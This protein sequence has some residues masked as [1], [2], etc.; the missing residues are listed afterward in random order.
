[1]KLRL[2]N[3][4]NNWVTINDKVKFLIDYPTRE[5]E[6]KLQRMLFSDIRN[7]ANQ[8]D[9]SQHLLK[10]TIKNWEGVTDDNDNEVK[11]EIVNNE[12]E[13]TLWWA[14][15]RD[16]EQLSTLYLLV[17]KAIEVTENDKKK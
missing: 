3:S 13:D 2:K 6:Q 16:V 5:Q 12:L 7:D 9:Y 1:M 11:C 4:L 15:V 17:K 10:Y 8:L 14:L